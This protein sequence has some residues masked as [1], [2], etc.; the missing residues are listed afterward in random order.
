MKKTSHAGRIVKAVC[1]SLLCLIVLAV[2]Y[3]FLAPLTERYQARPADGSADWMS[4][5]DDS[6]LLNE[7][8]IPGTHDSGTQYV[9][10]AY[11]SKCQASDIRTQLDD[12]FRYLDVRLGVSGE[13]GDARAL[14]Y[15][16][17]CRCRTGLLPWAPAL[18]L[19]TVLKDCYSFLE[20]HPSETVLFTVKQEQGNDTALLQALLDQAARKDPDKWL[21]TDRIPALGEARGRL[22]LLRRYD[23]AAGLGDR[24]GIYLNW[25][26]Q[27]GRDD[28]SLHVSWEAL[29]AGTLVVQDRYKY[30]TAEKWIAFTAGLREGTDDPEEIRLHFLSTNGSP[31]FGHPFAYAKTLNLFLEA[32]D[33]SAFPSS[34][35]IVDFSDAELAMTVY[36]LNFR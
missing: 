19:E 17:F 35:I 23:D 24:A 29:P 14:F 32:E 1:L 25:A 31:K 34:W 30:E 5:L 12:G 3:L 7:I 4:R 22:V 21:L 26:D 11:F 28:T 2:A 36:G 20:D 10:L 27:G 8:A 18:D 15:H 16:G 33:L 9:Q 6:L 13:D